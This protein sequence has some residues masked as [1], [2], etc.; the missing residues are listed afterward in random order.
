MA[1]QPRQGGAAHPVLTS[2]ALY[3][4]LPPAV[5]C[6]KLKSRTWCCGRCA[7]KGS[8]AAL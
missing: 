4:V 8:R 7:E 2:C 1:R 3:T 6:V 5:D